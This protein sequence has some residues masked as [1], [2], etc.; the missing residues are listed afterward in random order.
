M[1][2][3]DTDKQTQTDDATDTA[4]DTQTQEPDHKAEA[5][6][7]KALARKHE[8]QAKANATAATELAKIKEADKTEAQKAADKAAEMEQRATAAELASLRTDVALDKAPEGMSVAQVRKLAK[9]L[10]GAT[11]EELEA[12][13]VELFAEFTPAASDDSKRRPK[14][15]LRTGAT[16]D[17]EPDENDPKKLA[18]QVSR[19]W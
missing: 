8:T 2:T 9:R 14:E 7:W 16:G 10:A 17:T 11:R 3:S 13:A 4:A 5:E 12:D 19:G 6:K 15:R 1:E 18:A